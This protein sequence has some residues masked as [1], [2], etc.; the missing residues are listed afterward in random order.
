MILPQSKATAKWRKEN[1][2]GSRAHDIVK[3][4]K[5]AGRLV[6]GPCG[7]CGTTR[8]VHA[9]HE[10]YSQPLWV[11]WLCGKCHARKHWAGDLGGTS[12]A[13]PTRD[14]ADSRGHFTIDVADRDELRHRLRRLRREERLVISCRLRGCTLKETSRALG[15]GVSR[16]RIRLIQNRALR[17][18]GVA[19]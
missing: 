2:D 10:D 18:L 15:S 3:R 17:Q 6:P 14:L 11:Q 8:R 7:C 16:E 13:V 12:N 1:P 19:A 5:K 4:E 9:H